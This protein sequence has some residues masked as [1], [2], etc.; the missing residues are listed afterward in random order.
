[1]QDFNYGYLFIGLA[2]AYAFQLLLTGWQA[3]RYYRRLKELRKA[4]LTSVGMDGSKWKGRTYAVLVIDEEKRIKHAEML[5]G[6]TIFAKLKPVN[7]L[8]GLD[9]Q[10]LLDE[11]QVFKLSKRSLQAFRNA[12]LEY[13][14]PDNQIQHIEKMSEVKS[15]RMY[16]KK[17]SG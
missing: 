10:A 13:L 8:V 15:F 6:M 12:A 16:G 9:L 4:G 17:K 7:Q 5:S 2:I 3:R 11:N 14:K 1:M